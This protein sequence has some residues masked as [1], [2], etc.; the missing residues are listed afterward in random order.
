MPQSL[1]RRN[2]ACSAELASPSS[3]LLAQQQ[4]ALGFGGSGTE[5]NLRSSRERSADVKNV[6][7]LWQ[8]WFPGAVKIRQSDR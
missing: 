8:S 1:F 6:A 4:D 2:Q 5:R 7:A 3:K